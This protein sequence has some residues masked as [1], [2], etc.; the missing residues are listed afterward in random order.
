MR[1]DIES[2]MAWEKTNEQ[3]KPLMARSVAEGEFEVRCYKGLAGGLLDLFSGTA[4]F[5]SHKKTLGVVNG[6][7]WAQEAVLPYLLRENFE[8][9]N[10][11]VDQLS[12]PAAIMSA[13]EGE[14]SCFLWPED[15]PITAQVYSGESLEEALAKK[16]IFSIRLSH[17]A[18][19]T[20]PLK[21]NP[22]A[23]RLCSVTPE[24]A[25]AVT[26]ARFKTPAWIAASQHWNPN[27][28]AV[29]IES[30]FAETKESEDIVKKFEANLKAGWAPLL[31]ESKSWQQRIWDRALI[32]HPK[33]S[34]DQVVQEL[35]ALLQKP[36]ALPGEK[37]WVETLHLCRW[38][39][40]VKSFDWW[41]SRPAADLI[42]GS[43]MLDVS[44]LENPQ[45]IAYLAGDSR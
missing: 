10:F 38:D 23:V 36:I 8:I 42:R 43:V 37:S 22:Y 41:Q 29:Q 35:S 17:H 1:L 25:V 40:I 20:R 6:Q 13:L 45:V 34:G 14:T 16:R 18:F 24:L 19:L 30:S 5:L 7:S 33:K 11:T 15:N 27:Q 44:I 9:K 26:G 21:L 31:A 39:A 32:T 28:V 3:A 12:D 4:S 2:A